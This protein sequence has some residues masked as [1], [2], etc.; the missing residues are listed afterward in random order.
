MFQ[1]SF[2]FWCDSPVTF[3]HYKS[4]FKI[5]NFS[6]FWCIFCNSL[7][8]QYLQLLYRCYNYLPVAGLQ[9]IFQ[10]C[11]IAGFININGIIVGISLKCHG[12]L[13]VQI[14]SVNEK[15]CFINRRNIHKKIPCCFV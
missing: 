2:G 6:V 3:I 11:Y 4:D 10:I 1:F 8:D 5:F 15:D 13:C 9:F 7:T 14:S 12:C